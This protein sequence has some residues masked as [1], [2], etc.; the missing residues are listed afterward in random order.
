M[1]E[2]RSPSGIRSLGP[3]AED[4]AVISHAPEPARGWEERGQAIVQ[5]VDKA[6]R[7]LD[8]DGGADQGLRG[9]PPFVW[10]TVMSRP[11]DDRAI[12]DAS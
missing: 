12:V 3:P 4:F 1:A 5:A 9:E 8:R 11:T 7:N 6:G 2:H 10:A